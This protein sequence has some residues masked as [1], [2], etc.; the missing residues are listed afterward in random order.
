MRIP[1]KFQA[2]P[3]IGLSLYCPL[4]RQAMSPFHTTLKGRAYHLCPTCRF[5]LLDPA[6]H[7]SDQA[8]K[9]RYR[10]HKNSADNPGYVAM[11]QKFID[12]CVRPFAKPACRTL[13]L[14]C[15]P[16]PVLAGLLREA[17]HP[18]E[19]FDPFF[20][21]QIPPGNFDLVTLTEVLEHLPDPVAAL[22]PWVGRLAP[23]GLLA[24][25]TRFHPD[26]PLKFGAWPYRR[27][28]TH[29]SFYVPKTLDIV[30]RALGLSARFTDGERY[31][32]WEKPAG[33]ADSP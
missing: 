3:G 28:I 1:Q 26:D 11:F 16:G 5:I 12:A 22:R 30:A 10:E 19:I 18:T 31:F 14:G 29:V 7:S 15:G 9:E 20:F 32:V 4:C 24:G 2:V 13:D 8:Q 25:M 21:P 33:P 23:G 6:L 17:G 27:D